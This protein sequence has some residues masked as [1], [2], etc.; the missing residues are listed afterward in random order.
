MTDSFLFA[1][2][3]GAFAGVMTGI[4][5][6]SGMMAVVPGMI[7]LGY[8]AY[9]AI[10]ISLAVDVIAASI[11]AFA[12]YRNG[13]VDMGRGLWIATAAVVGAQLGSR[14]LF[15]IPE[16]G[17]NGGFGILLLLTAVSFW[18]DGIGQGGVRRNLDRFQNVPFMRRLERHP[19][20]V[21]ITIGL[22]VGIVSGMLG[23][24]GGILFMFSLL[25]MGYRLHTA[26]GTST[27][28]MALTTIS[29]TIGHAMLGNLP[30]DAIL[31]ASIGTVFGSFGSARLANQLSESALSKMIALVFATLGLALVGIT[32]W[33]AF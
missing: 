25:V 31:F 16:S 17:L 4:M 13:N 27:M 2:L 12:Y 9:Q 14:L 10:G 18:R 6:A 1:L 11:V 23:V 15:R 33:Q 20:S 28:I 5:G 30:Y 22:L 29:G 3:V 19:I 26:V 32:I 21:S 8:S 7:L 24:G